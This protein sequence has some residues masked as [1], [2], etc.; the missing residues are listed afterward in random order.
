M[1]TGYLGKGE[2]SN[3]GG[4][5]QSGG[6]QMSNGS[7]FRQYAEEALRWARE[8]KSKKEKETLTGLADTWMRAALQSEHILFADSNP[9]E[10]KIN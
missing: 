4:A 6:C 1:G 7:E 5:R 10:L 2:T 3:Q 8:A 9:Q